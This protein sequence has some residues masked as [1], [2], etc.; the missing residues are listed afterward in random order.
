MPFFNNIKNIVTYL[1]ISGGSIRD[2]PSLELYAILHSVEHVCINC[3]IFDTEGFIDM[4]CR[5]ANPMCP[6]MRMLEF[7]VD[8]RIFQGE[9]GGALVRLVEERKERSERAGLLPISPME[10]IV[11]QSR[12]VAGWALALLRNLLGEGNVT[13]V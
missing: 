3:G 6:Q 5:N 9:R 13:A 8:E 12:T 2:T 7:Y 1:N 10:E 4:S 11:V